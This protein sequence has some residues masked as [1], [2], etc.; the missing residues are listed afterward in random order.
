MGHRHQEP[1]GEALLLAARST[2][3]ASGVRA[4]PSQADFVWIEVGDAALFT[5]RIAAFGMQVVDGTPRGLPR[6]VRIAVRGRADVIA[7]T[8]AMRRL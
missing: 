6:H 2:L 3:E 1:E 7:L 5:Q 4:L 8:D